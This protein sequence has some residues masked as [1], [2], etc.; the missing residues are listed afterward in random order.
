MPSCLH[1]FCA[2]CSHRLARKPPTC[3]LRAGVRVKRRW[4]NPSD[5]LFLPTHTCFLEQTLE[6]Q[7]DPRA[8]Q[9]I[10]V[11]VNKVTAGRCRVPQAH[12]QEL[13][14]PQGSPAIRRC[15]PA[16]RQQRHFIGRSKDLSIRMP[17]SVRHLVS[18]SC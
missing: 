9:G 18:V 7:I 16:Q 2:A 4:D 15:P 12:R 11:P 14:L 17:A 13:S 5:T 8:L 10:R 3:S 1:P 6:A